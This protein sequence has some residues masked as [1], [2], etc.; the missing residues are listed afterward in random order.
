MTREQ[1]DAKVAADTEFEG[2]A[3][4]GPH[5]YLNCAEDCED[6]N[7]SGQLEVEIEDGLTEYL[8]CSCRVA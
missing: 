5:G 7:G 8:P 2:G 4:Y 1:Y 3:S 6:C